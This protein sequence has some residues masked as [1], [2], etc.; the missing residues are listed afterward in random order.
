MAERAYAGRNENPPMELDAVTGTLTFR[1]LI[2][3]PDGATKFHNLVGLREAL[4]RDEAGA[5]SVMHAD[6]DRVASFVHTPKAVRRGRFICHFQLMAAPGAVKAKALDRLLA[7]SADAVV[8]LPRRD[9]P[10]D[11]TSRTAWDNCVRDVR[12]TRRGTGI[13]IFAVD[14]CDVDTRAS[15]HGLYRSSGVEV[16]ASPGDTGVAMVSI[17]ERVR[18]AVL[19]QYDA[20]DATARS[21]MEE[22]PAQRKVTVRAQPVWF[23]AAAG[24]FGLTGIALLAWWAVQGF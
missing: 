5:V 3:G 15:Q 24:A 20:L 21:R 9:E 6:G 8:F 7:Q 14:Y 22:R 13:P 17:Y 2:S 1:I 11:D 4:P 19:R 10:G 18:A 23:F 16:V 12:G